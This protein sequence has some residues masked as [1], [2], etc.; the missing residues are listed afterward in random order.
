MERNL[1]IW[2]TSPEKKIRPKSHLTW[3]KCEEYH[4]FVARNAT[5]GCQISVKSPTA[6]KNMKIE[7]LGDTKTPRFSVELLREHYVPCEEA[8]WPDPVVPDCGEFDLEPECNVTYLINVKTDKDTVAGEYSL[9]VRLSENGEIYG[10]YP[11]TVSVWNFS[12]DPKK[13]MDTAFGIGMRGIK[14]RQKSDD[15][16][17]LYK[18]YYD[19]LLYRYRIC[20]YSLPYDILDPRADEY[21][22]DPAVTTF[23]IPYDV[24]DETIT[25]YYEKLSKNET[26]LKKGFFYVVDEP[27]NMAAYEKI[28]A[29]HERLARLF[30]GYQAVSPFFKDP[31]DGNG[32]R[33]VDLLEPF[34]SVWCPK[35]N[36]YKDEWFCDYMH[37]RDAL[38]DRSWWY[39]CWEPGLPY[40]NVFIDM[41]GFHHRVLLWQQFLHDVRG[42]LYWETTWWGGEGVPW[43][44]ASSVRGLNYYC[45]GDGSL[46]YP[47]DRIGIDGPVGSL[48]LEILRYGIEDFYMLSLA[49]E[50]FGREWVDEKVKFVT[51]NIREYNEDHDALD[52][53]R[54]EIGNALSEYSE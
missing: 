7:V 37:K 49:E 5:E 52:R 1:K 29:S 22:D 54:I 32:L 18:K 24:P 46:F 53:V 34:C 41:D 14:L 30:P 10:D 11:L 12:I 8:L 50:R 3:G 19:M 31:G 13:H 47:G 45:F 9:T 2:F 6:R 28:K 42:L 36:L 21:L 4:V 17:A 16:E 38:G 25:E 39:V 40:S 27:C 43:D 48:R 51:P 35:I 44:S 23:I 20:G 15:Y 33:A 26:W